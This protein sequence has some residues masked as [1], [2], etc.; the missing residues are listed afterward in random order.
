MALI[1]QEIINT[2]LFKVGTMHMC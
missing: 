1:L 2:E